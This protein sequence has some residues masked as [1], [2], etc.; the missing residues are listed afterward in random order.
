MATRQP[1]MTASDDSTDRRGPAA[2]LRRSLFVAGVIALVI[3][4]L[5]AYRQHDIQARPHEIAA[6]VVTRL[7][8]APYHAHVRVT[9][10]HGAPFD[11]FTSSRSPLAV[12]ERVRVRRSGDRT[13]PGAWLDDGDPYGTA[14]DVALIGVGLLIG[15]AASPWLLARFPRVLQSPL[16]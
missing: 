10:A 11:W 14:I 16:R 5:L 9:P 2:R 7:D 8:P 12:G 15:A 6:G 1:V 3:A 13:A 4:G